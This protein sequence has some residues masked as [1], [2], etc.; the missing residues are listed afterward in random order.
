MMLTLL[1]SFFLIL[2]LNLG[3]ELIANC[4]EEPIASEITKSQHNQTF[5]VT[6][7]GKFAS[8][9]ITISNARRFFVFF[10]CIFLFEFFKVER[11]EFL[12]STARCVKQTKKLFATFSRSGLAC[13]YV[14]YRIT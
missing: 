14:R 1:I 12:A 7:A 5:Q 11:K 13:S 3:L 8:E 10:F 9:Q 6:F 4:K 2:E